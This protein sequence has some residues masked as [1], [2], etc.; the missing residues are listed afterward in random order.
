MNTRSK[1]FVFAL[2]S[3]AAFGLTSAALQAQDAT[4]ATTPA[5]GGQ[6]VMN[7]W[8]K[9]AERPQ[10]SPELQAQVDAFRQDRNAMLQAFRDQYAEEREQIHAL[11]LK[12]QNGELTEEEKAA[13]LEEIKG[14]KETHREQV[15]SV[16]EGLR[17]QMRE[18]REQIRKER[19]GTTPEG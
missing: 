1:K 9:N 13:V 6:R 14:M 10:L 19:A 12:Y 4:D 8:G 7:Q 11:M 17:T 2:L 15:R 16:R 3:A 18:I 5:P